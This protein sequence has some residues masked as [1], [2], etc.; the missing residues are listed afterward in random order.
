MQSFSFIIF[1]HESE[2]KWPKD[3]YVQIHQ[4][5]TNLVIILAT[6]I[7]PIVE[8]FTFALKELLDPMDVRLVTCSTLKRFNVTIQKTSLDGKISSLTIMYDL[9]LSFFNVFLFSNSEKYYGDID[10]KT[11]KKIKARN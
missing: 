10:P 1:W 5:L 3:S 6:L 2:Q 9:N 4:K 11:V 7:L 8:S